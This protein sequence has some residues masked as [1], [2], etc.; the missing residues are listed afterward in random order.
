LFIKNIHKRKIIE[1]TSLFGGWFLFSLEEIENNLI[2]RRMATLKLLRFNHNSTS[3]PM[4]FININRNSI[5]NQQRLFSTSTNSI[6]GGGVGDN[7]T[8]LISTRLRQKF[9]NN[10]IIK[11]EDVSGGCGDFFDIVVESS[12]FKN[13]SM[14][15]QHRMITE[16]ITDIDR[17]GATIKTK[18]SST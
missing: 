18:V 14:V 12:L 1:K 8:T 2:K 15:Q 16:L 9:G 7:K 4:W 3:R 6:G 11:V 10:A 17:H 5:N 13:I